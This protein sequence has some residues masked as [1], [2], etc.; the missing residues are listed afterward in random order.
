M[1]LVQKG[2]LV[3]GL[4]NAVIGVAGFLGPLIT[5]NDDGLINIH[6]GNLFG[7]IAIDWMHAA[8]HLA[9]GV[10]GVAAASSAASSRLWFG[11]IT[12]AFAVLAIYGWV[13]VGFDPSMHILL[14]MGFDLEGNVLHTLWTAIG[15]FFLFPMGAGARAPRGAVAR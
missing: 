14:G 11:I 1:T 12:A 15:L 5:G 8:A 9:V 2:A 6:H 3:F 13:A 10:L 7:F 4:V